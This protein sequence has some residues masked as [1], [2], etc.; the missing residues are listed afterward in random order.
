M[1]IKELRWDAETVIPSR[2]VSSQVWTNRGYRI[3]GANRGDRHDY[4]VLMMRPDTVER[5][6]RGK[7]LR[8]MTIIVND[9]DRER[10]EYIVADYGTYPEKHE[11]IYTP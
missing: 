4:G 11:V 3:D 9:T 6:S 8:S 2:L 10:V 1:N 7:L 5:K